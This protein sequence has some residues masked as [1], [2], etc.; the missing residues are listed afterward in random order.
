MTVLR[1]NE[2]RLFISTFNVRRTLK[3]DV[4]TV[5]TRSGFT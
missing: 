4:P 1:R 3:P 2:I 5:S